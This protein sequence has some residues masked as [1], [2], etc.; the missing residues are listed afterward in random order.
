MVN[1]RFGFKGGSGIKPGKPGYKGN[2]I[3][4]SSSEGINRKTKPWWPREEGF[5]EISFISTGK[6]S[7]GEEF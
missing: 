7:Q 4:S 1:G 5:L 3:I 6:S 2:A